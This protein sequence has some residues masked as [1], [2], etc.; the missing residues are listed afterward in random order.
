MT[1]SNS[2]VHVGSDGEAPAC[3]LGPD[4]FT[5]VNE[6]WYGQAFSLK[7]KQEVHRER[8]KYQDILVLDR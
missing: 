1:S 2:T 7:I 5:E 4:W 3:K 8:S 6:L